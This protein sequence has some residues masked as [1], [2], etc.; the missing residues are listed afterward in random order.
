MNQD[1]NR[2][3]VKRYKGLYKRN[4]FFECGDGWFLPIWHA[5]EKLSK[6]RIRADQVKEKFGGIRFYISSTKK[7]YVIPKEV[8]EIIAELET[9]CWRLDE[10]FGTDKP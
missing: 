2:L 1:F 4:F 8:D 9:Q 3:L 5:S 6:F 7:G 10:H